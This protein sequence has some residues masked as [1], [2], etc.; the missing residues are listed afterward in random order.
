MT[1]TAVGDLARSLQSRMA[2]MRL[3]AEM[4]RL[5]QEVG[6]G[7]T[8][9]LPQRVSGDFGPLASLESRLARL[10]GYRTA[11][12]E[13]RGLID[14]AQTALTAI[15]GRLEG[16]GAEMIAAGTLGALSKLQVQGNDAAERFATVVTALNARDAGR[17]VFAG[18]ASGGQA[19]APA[20]DML[21][22]IETAV[23]GESTAA[24]VVA[25][26]DAWFGAGGGFETMGYLGAG[27][28]PG[29]LGIGPDRT[30]EMNLTAAD[31]RLRAGLR[32][33][34]LGAMLARGPLLSD[35]AEQAQ[36]ARQAGEAIVAAETGIVGLAAE[37]GVKQEVVA[38]EQAAQTAERTALQ[39]ARNEIVGVDPF[40]S[41]SRLQEIQLQL[42]SFYAV[43]ART[44]RLSL[45]EYLR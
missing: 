30:I 2:N 18:T 39:I 23:A 43:T 9:D 24:G 16:F 25:T 40:E 19:L 29:A 33:L 22:A 10:E 31:D 17:S 35:P 34:A 36:L 6:S 1:V 13:A 14:T 44:S 42:E 26:V 20:A 4:N 41:A 3:A 37:T 21:A 7:R 27:T 11:A 38:A 45:T 32:G 5:V 15:R 12:T 8:A 28:A